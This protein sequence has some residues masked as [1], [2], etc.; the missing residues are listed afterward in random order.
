LLCDALA[1]DAAR[2]LVLFPRRPGGQPQMS[3]SLA[4]QAS[5]MTSVRELQTWIA[6]HLAAKLSV[7]DRADRTR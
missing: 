1:H 5:S 3:V 4:S 2:E 7:D 6:E